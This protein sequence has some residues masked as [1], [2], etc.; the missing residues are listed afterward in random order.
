M[1]PRGVYLHR[2]HFL[3]YIVVLA[4]LAGCANPPNNHRRAVRINE[5][6]VIGSHNSYHLQAPAPLRAL[7]AEHDPAEAKSLEY[8]HRPLG[9]QFYRGIRQ[10]ELDC[11]ADPVGGLFAHPLG[12]KAAREAGLPAVPDHDPEGKLR[13]PGIKVLHVKDV[14]YFTS[15]LTLVDGLKQVRDWSDGNPHH[16]PILILLELKDATGLSN[17]N[18][19][20]P[21]DKVQLA[22]LETEILSVFS[23]DRILAPDDVRGRAPTLADGLRKHGWPTVESARGK[24]IFA[25]DNEGP[26]RDL[27]LEGH[28]ALE[29]RLL[30]VSVPP[31]H[32]AAGWMKVN[33]VLEGFERIQ[34][35]V[36]AGFL[37]RTR[38]DIGTLEARANDTNRREKA[39]ASGAQFISTDYPEPNLAFSNYSVRFDNGIVVRSN[40]VN[41]NPEL[42]GMDLER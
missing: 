13:K 19:T 32:P 8:G 40:P 35:L 42:R 24:V 2:A 27:Y 23:R 3:Q 26:V 36:E 4:L 21:F 7:I 5:V 20:V 41:G 29:R 34:S 14:D 6:Q 18:P 17:Q 39:F 33:D 28:P 25:L 16:F 11:Y 38:A 9:D 30:F 12:R 1:F 22:A 15:V 10:I 31:E 37:V